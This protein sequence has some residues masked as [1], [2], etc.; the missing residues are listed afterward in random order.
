MHGEGVLR[1]P[2]SDPNYLEVLK[3]IG[4]LKPGETRPVP[5]W[6]D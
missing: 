1:Y 6:P 3:H 5:P 2:P 4:P